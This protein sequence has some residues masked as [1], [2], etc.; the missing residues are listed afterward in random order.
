[1]SSSELVNITVPS[2]VTIFMVV[3]MVIHRFVELHTRSDG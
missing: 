2:A 1:M 3:M